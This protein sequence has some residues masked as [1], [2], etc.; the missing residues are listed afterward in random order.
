MDLA[1]STDWLKLIRLV[2]ITSGPPN[3]YID[4]TSKAIAG[5]CRAVQ[6]RDKQ[7][8][9]RPFMEIA[10]RIKRV[11]DAQGALFFINDRVDVASIVGSSGVHLGV[12]DISISDARGLLRPGVILGYS[13]EGES[14]AVEALRSG[15]DYLGVGPVFDTGTKEDAGK[16]I[17]VNGL[18]RY[19]KAGTVPV[20]AVGGIRADRVREVIRSGVSGVAVSS[21]ISGAPDPAAETRSILTQIEAGGT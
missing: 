12:S 20:I 14:D 8:D 2:V 6:L 4:I 10:L 21:A 18:L 15:A 17:G 1:V 3:G 11:C 19:Q 7:L 13:P 5:G 16:P 9:D